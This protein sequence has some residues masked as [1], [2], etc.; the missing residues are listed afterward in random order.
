M[1]TIQPLARR[2]RAR[3]ATIEEIKQTARDLMREQGTT[4]VRFSD[5]ARVMGLT[6]PALYRYFADRDALLTAL[7]TD[8][9]DE[10]AAAIAEARDAVPVGAT[11][12]RLLA[13]AEAYRSWARAEPERF[14]LLFGL[15]VPGYEAPEEGTTTEAAQRA[16]SQLKAIFF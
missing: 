10:L 2:E 13:V 14:A 12:A 15:P 4:D 6:A 9:F 11:G 7:I 3:A 8:S 5:I 1:T 16:M